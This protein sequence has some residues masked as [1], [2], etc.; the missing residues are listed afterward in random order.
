VASSPFGTRRHSLTATRSRQEALYASL[1]DVR[2]PHSHIP[3]LRPGARV[4]Q[5]WPKFVYWRLMAERGQEQRQS[6]GWYTLFRFRLL[7]LLVATAVLIVVGVVVV[8]AAFSLVASASQQVLAAVIVTSGTILVSVGSLILSN[9]YQQRQQAHQ[10]QHSRKADVYQELLD[11]WFW[12]MRDRKKVPENKRKQTDEKYR[13]TVPQKLITWGSED[14]IKEFTAQVGPLGVNEETSMLGFEKL[15][16]AIRKDLGHSN[17]GLEDGDLLR[18]FLTGVDEALE[19]R[20]QA[21]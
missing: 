12:A 19:D 11:Y 7:I 16:F 10:A 6:S 8:R 14:V 15:L 4:A 9:R 20:K 1:E 2:E 5:L 3:I 17:K 21:N 13:R 18:P